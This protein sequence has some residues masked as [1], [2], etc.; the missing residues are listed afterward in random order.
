MCH[1]CFLYQETLFQGKKKKKTW[2]IF[3]SVSTQLTFVD[4]CQSSSLNSVDL[5]LCFSCTLKTMNREK[6]RVKGKIEMKN[7]CLRTMRLNAGMLWL[8]NITL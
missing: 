6:Y 5:N 1:I 3:L 2:Q 8:F 4:Q 7:V